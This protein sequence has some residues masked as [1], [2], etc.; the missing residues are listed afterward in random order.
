MQKVMMSG[1]ALF[2]A[3]TPLLAED[4]VFFLITGERLSCIQQNAGDYAPSA[5]DETVFIMVEDCGTDG[6]GE[7]SLLD[8]VVNSAPDISVDES[9]GPDAVV[10]LSGN[11]FEC[12]SSISFPNGDTLMA[13]YP[14]Q[15]NVEIRE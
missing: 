14:G 13:F 15:C 12:L 9:G 3:A 4:D 5:E 1:T 11:D 10:A 2:L 6:A 8:Q 7:V